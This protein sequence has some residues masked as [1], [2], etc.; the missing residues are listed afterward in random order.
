[1]GDVRKARKFGMEFKETSG[2]RDAL[3]AFRKQCADIGTRV[4]D[5]RRNLLIE[6]QPPVLLQLFLPVRKLPLLLT[7]PV[8][9]CVMADS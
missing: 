1:M 8:M 3:D 9:N 6:P 7:I 4:Y 5:L 2:I